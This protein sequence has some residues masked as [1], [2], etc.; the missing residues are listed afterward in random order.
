MPEQIQPTLCKHYLYLNTQTISRK[1]P[2]RINQINA[3]KTGKQTYVAENRDFQIF[4]G[5]VM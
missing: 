4:G 3:P 2:H 5:T 1:S